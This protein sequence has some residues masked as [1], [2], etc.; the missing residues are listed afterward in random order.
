MT[1]VTHS[2]FSSQPVSGA[3][4]PHSM[5]AKQVIATETK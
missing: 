2:P 5:A 4:L 1:V 3:L